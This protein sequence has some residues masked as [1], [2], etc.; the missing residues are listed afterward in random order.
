[1]NLI[2]LLLPIFHN[3]GQPVPRELLEEVNYELTDKF[4]GVTVYSRAPAEGIWRDDS[5]RKVRDELLLFEVMA[6]DVDRTWW[7]S[8]RKRLEERFEQQEILIR[9]FAVEQL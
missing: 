9:S 3:D 4:G 1:M 8:Y 7:Q 5:A 2:Q 6:P